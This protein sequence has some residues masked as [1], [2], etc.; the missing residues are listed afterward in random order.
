MG[1]E[2]CKSCRLGPCAR[3]QKRCEGLKEDLE[4][5]DGRNYT[6]DVYGP[7]EKVSLEKEGGRQ[8]GL[9]EKLDTQVLL[10]NLYDDPDSVRKRGL[11]PCLRARR[12]F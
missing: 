12:S 4:L 2:G 3:S 7:G 6:E 11:P 9:Q 8:L 1:K 10:E 5:L